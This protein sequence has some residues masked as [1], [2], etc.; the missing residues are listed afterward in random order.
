[1][2]YLLYI[3][4]ETFRSYG[5]CRW[6]SDYLA[7]WFISDVVSI[8]SVWISADVS[9]SFTCLSFHFSLEDRLSKLNNWKKI[10]ECIS[11]RTFLMFKFLVCSSAGATV[12]ALFCTYGERLACLM[13]LYTTSLSEKPLK[14]LC[15]NKVR[16]VNVKKKNETPPAMCK[17]VYSSSP[18]KISTLLVGM[19]CYL[20]PQQNQN[21]LCRLNVWHSVKVLHY[22][23]LRFFPQ[24]IEAHSLRTLV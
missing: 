12:F 18:Y 5:D 22:W 23:M 6:L 13:L 4:L 2:K 10:F 3:R 8:K 14:G 19:F 20:T 17:Y 21:K 11:R 7:G 16:N 15:R 1:M 24:S 9:Y